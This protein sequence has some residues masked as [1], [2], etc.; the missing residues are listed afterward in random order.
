MLLLLLT[1]TMLLSVLYC[2]INFIANSADMH[3][4]QIDYQHFL[5]VYLLLY[6]CFP[7]LTLLLQAPV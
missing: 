3:L 1:D 7:T 5:N 4:G 2:I 6:S